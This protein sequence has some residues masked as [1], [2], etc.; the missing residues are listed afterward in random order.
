MDLW[1]IPRAI[2]DYVFPACK[3]YPEECYGE[4]VTF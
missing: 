3:A 1:I 2:I 4:D